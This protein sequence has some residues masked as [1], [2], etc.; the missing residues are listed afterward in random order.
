MPQL[1]CLCAESPGKR[2][3]AKSSHLTRAFLLKFNLSALHGRSLTLSRPS[4]RLAT[5]CPPATF[6]PVSFF[7][8]TPGRP[9]ESD[10]PATV[11]SNIRASKPLSCLPEHYAG[12][13]LKTQISPACFEEEPI[14]SQSH[15]NASITLC[16][17]KNGCNAMRRAFS[18]I[19]A[20]NI[21]PPFPLLQLIL[22]THKGRSCLSKNKTAVFRLEI[23]FPKPILSR[24]FR[25]HP[26]AQITP[27]IDKRR[28]F[29]QNSGSPR[30][31]PLSRSFERAAG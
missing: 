13:P 6:S 1:I 29:S 7:P 26:F 24:K 3:M 27:L 17:R 14:K 18:S 11:R 20:L 19:P 22:A 28:F 25:M 31:S 10:S 4:A 16:G 30:A 9:A 23:N 12:T 8:V 21:K 2:D 5:A 15:P